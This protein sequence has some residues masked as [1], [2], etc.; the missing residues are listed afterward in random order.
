M[1]RYKKACDRLDMHGQARKERGQV[2]KQISFF[3]SI[4][5][6]VNYN[7]LVAQGLRILME[8]RRKSRMC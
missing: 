3:N 7:D 2:I 1:N 6:N 4:F 8:E 5:R